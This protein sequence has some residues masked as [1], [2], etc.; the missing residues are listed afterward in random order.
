[1]PQL[2]QKPALRSLLSGLWACKISVACGICCACGKYS[3]GM[4][5]A[6]P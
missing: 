2:Q 4:F 1:M 6:M 5:V 3:Q